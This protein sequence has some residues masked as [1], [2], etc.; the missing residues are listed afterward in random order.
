MPRESFRRDLALIGMCVRIECKSCGKPT[1]AGCGAHVDQVL[2]G[3]PDTARCKCREA[4]RDARAA[5]KKPRW[6]F[7]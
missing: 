6:R 3:V 5:E 4:K 1:Y 2:R 7:W